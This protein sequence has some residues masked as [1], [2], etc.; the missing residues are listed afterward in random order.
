MASS[1]QKML[2]QQAVHMAAPTS[3]ASPFNK[4]LAN[5]EPS[6]HGYKRTSM[7]WFSMSAF[8]PK[9][10]IGGHLNDVRN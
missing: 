2:H 3:P 4:S 8:R 7:I 5:R 1:Y 10:D 9:A 6:T